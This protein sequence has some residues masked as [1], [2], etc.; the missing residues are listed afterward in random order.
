MAT[1]G[2]LT[3]A[4]AVNA[5]LA[6]SSAPAPPSNDTIPADCPLGMDQMFWRLCDLE[7]LWGI[8]M[9]GLAGFGVLLTFALFVCYLSWTKFVVRC[10]CVF[11]F[12]VGFCF[13][14]FFLTKPNV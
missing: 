14:V 1:T 12:S 11:C 7:L 13:C 5:S 3:T 10:V 9:E 6:P 2:A 8:I 4:F